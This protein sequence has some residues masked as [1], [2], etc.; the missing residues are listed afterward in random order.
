MTWHNKFYS[1]LFDR[2]YMKQVLYNDNFA[3]DEAL[4]D[5]VI[6]IHVKNCTFGNIM[7]VLE[8]MLVY[9]N[10]LYSADHHKRKEYLFHCAKQKSKPCPP[11]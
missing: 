11:I 6:K 9:R 5:Q 4:E 8:N 3:L 2:I 1:Q 7:C 10:I